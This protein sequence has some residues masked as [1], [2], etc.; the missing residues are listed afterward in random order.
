MMMD[1]R[2]LIPQ[3]PPFLFL[4]AIDELSTENGRA[5]YRFKEDEFFFA[6]HF[7]GR[8]VVPGVIQI[9]V[10][11]QLMVAVG[12]YTLREQGGSV[13]DIFFTRATECEFH[14]VLGPGDEVTV[15]CEKQWFRMRTI[16]T[17]GALFLAATGELVAEA[18]TRGSGNQ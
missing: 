8:P 13:R 10:M 3:R 6:G 1:P 2:E 12:L 16:Q 15:T 18:I 4:D 5:R 11:A 17:K 14:R 7:P 9:E